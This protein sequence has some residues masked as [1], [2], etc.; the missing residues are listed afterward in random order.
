[1]KSELTPV[2]DLRPYPNNARTHSRKQLRQIA[3]SIEKF[4]F[5]NPVLVDDTNQIIAGHGRVEAAKLL[6]IEAVPT[7]RLSHLSDADKRAYILAICHDVL[8]RDG[9]AVRDGGFA[10]PGNGLRAARSERVQPARETGDALGAVAHRQYAHLLF[11]YMH[12]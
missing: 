10:L 6:G 4:G 11:V 2:R 1:M 9:G 8:A 12:R 7:C 5:C 3:R